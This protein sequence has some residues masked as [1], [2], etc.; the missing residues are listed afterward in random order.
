MNASKLFAAI[1]TLAFAGSAFAAGIPAANATASTAAAAAAQVSVAAKSLNVP[2]ILPT[3]GGPTRAEVR[4]EAEEAVRNRR[5]SEASQFDWL[6][7]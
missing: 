6:T 5:S 4:A 1:A 2:A 7:K 3:K